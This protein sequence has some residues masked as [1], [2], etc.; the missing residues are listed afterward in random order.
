M[1]ALRVLV[2]LRSPQ[3][4]TLTLPSRRS[5][6]E[7]ACANRDWS[8]EGHCISGSTQTA[9]VGRCRAEI[10]DRQWGLLWSL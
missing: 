1:I 2:L 7:P 9:Y 10:L 3:G 4:L 8:T 6:S 5:R